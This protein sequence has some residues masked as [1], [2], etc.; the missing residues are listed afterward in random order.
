MVTVCMV[1]TGQEEINL[2]TRFGRFQQDLKLTSKNVDT[3]NGRH[4]FLLYFQPF[5]GTQGHHG[6]QPFP[7]PSSSSI[8]NISY[9][10]NV[11]IHALPLFVQIHPS[12]HP[13]YICMC[14]YI[15][16][17]PISLNRVPGSLESIPGDS[18]EDTLDTLR[19]HH[20]TPS[21]SHIHTLWTIQR[22]Q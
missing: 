17:I 9:H 15:Y 7:F 8:C 14:V 6:A 3:G 16:P 2:L 22:C 10:R 5:F 12:I 19:T 18:A 21:H 20:R 1:H 4:V 13:L 11:S